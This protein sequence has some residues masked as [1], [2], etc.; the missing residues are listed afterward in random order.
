MAYVLYKKVISLTYRDDHALMRGDAMTAKDV[1]GA[2]SATYRKAVNKVAQALRIDPNHTR[3]P[4][5]DFESISD[6]IDEKSRERAFQWYRRGLRRGFEEACDAIVEG[7]LELK[8]NTLYCPNK[9]VISVR[10]KFKDAPRVE[11]E[12]TFSADDLGFK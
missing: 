2:A 5:E 10:M 7:K 4:S 1:I 3:Y 9:V 12:F 6:L 11:H 8:G